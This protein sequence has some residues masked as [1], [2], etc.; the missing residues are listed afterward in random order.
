ST[1]W[2]LDNTIPSIQFVTPLQTGSFYNSNFSL[3]IF[4][5]NHKL[6]YSYY[7]ITNST[8]DV[9]QSNSINLAQA[10]YTWSD[11]VDVDSLA[12][13]NYTVKVFAEDSSETVHNTNVKS[14]WFYVDKTAP[15]A[16][17][18]DG[19][20]VEPTP[21]DNSYTN[22]QTQTFN[23]TC[24]ETFVDE[25]WIDFNGTLDS[26]PTGSSGIYYWWTFASLEGAYSY[27]GY[28]NDTA[29]NLNQTETRTLNVDI[30]DP[31]WSNNKTSP[32]TPDTYSLGASYQFN[33]TWSD[34]FAGLGTAVIEHNFSGSIGN[35]SFSGSSGGEYYYDVNNLAAGVYVWRSYANDS[36]G[37]DAVSDQ[38]SYVVQKASTVL[39]LSPSPG[40][41]VANGTETNISC[42]ANNGEVNF[43]LWRNST[44]IG[45]SIGGTVSDVQTLGI[46]SYNYTCNTSGSQNYTSY[47]VSDLLVVNEKFVSVC[48]LDIIPVNG[49]VYPVSVNATCDCSSPE[50][51]AKLY[52]DSVDVTATENNTA[53]PLAAG[54]Y[55]YVCNVSETQN[56]TYAENSTV[57]TIVGAAS[58]INLTLDGVDDDLTV[59]SGSVVVFNVTL[60]PIDGVGYL[61]ED[62]GLLKSSTTPFGFSKQYVVPGDYVILANHSGS[63]NYTSAN[64]NHTLTVEDTTDPVVS[65]IT[66]LDSDI[67]GW[68]VLLRANATD[69]NLDTIWFEIRNGTLA[70]AVI[71]SGVMNNYQ[72]DLFNGTLY[73][74]ETWPYDVSLLNST[75]L[76]FVVYAN[77]TSGN[78]VN[79]STYW[80]LDNTIPSIQYV[81]P[82]QS[83]GF[84]NSDFNLEIFLANHKLNYSYYNITNSTSDVVQSNSID[85]AQATYTWNDLVDVDSLAEGNYT[86]TT[87]ARDSSSPQNNNTKVTW[88]YVDKTAP[89]LTQVNETGWVVPTPA[90]N[91]YT[92][93]QTQTFN[94]T[95]NETFI[96]EVWIDF[97][98]TL[99]STPTGSSGI[100]YWW[101]FA[102]LEGTYSYTG[103]CNDTAGNQQQTDTRS[104]NVDITPPATVTSLIMLSRGENWIEWSWNNPLDSDYN[105]AILYI[106]DV[107]T[108]NL[109]SPTNSYNLSGL[110]CSEIR[111]LTIHTKDNLDNVNS[112]DVTNVTSTL[113]CPNAVILNTSISPYAVINGSD[114]ELFI[115]AKAHEAV[116]ARIDRPDGSEENITLVNDSAVLYSSIDLMGRY[117]VTFYANNSI[118][119]IVSTTDYFESFEGV[120]FDL[121]VIDSDLVGLDSSFTAYYRNGD[122]AINSSSTGNYTVFMVDTILD[123][124]FHAYSDRLYVTTRDTNISDII[125][126]TLGID[127]HYNTTG[128]LVTY[129]IE[130]EWVISDGAVRIYYD[131]LNY[132]VEG[133]LRLYRCD[134]YVFVNE[135]CLDAWS[136]ITSQSGKN[137]VS[138]YFE[139][140]VTSFSGFSIKEEG[141][142]TPPSTGGAGGGLADIICTPVWVCSN[143]EP[144]VCSESGVQ[145]RSCV[146]RANCGVD[147]GA[148]PPLTRDCIYKE[149]IIETI[150]YDLDMDL[151]SSDEINQGGDF[152][153]EVSLTKEDSDKLSVHLTYTIINEDG[154]VVISRRETKTLGRELEFTKS[155]GT[156]KLEPGDYT[157]IVKATYDGELISDDIKFTVLGEEIISEERAPYT[158]F[159]FK[160]YLRSVHSSSCL[161]FLPSS[162]C[163][164]LVTLTFCLVIILFIAN[165][166]YADMSSYFSYDM[167][168]YISK[169]R[170]PSE[171]YIGPYLKKRLGAF[172]TL[173][174]K[175]ASKLWN[176]FIK[177]VS[178][179]FLAIKK[180]LFGKPPL[181]G[182][183]EGVRSIFNR[184]VRWFKKEVKKD[185]KQGRRMYFGF[186]REVHRDLRLAEQ[187]VERDVWVL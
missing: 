72:G 42:G 65:V 143:W 73:T 125:N 28:C 66:P 53:I 82:S 47:V 23:M 166:Y 133:N 124:E 155:F 94:M 91:A 167:D 64:E 76:T 128:Y 40:W 129:G 153:V 130:P 9:I 107:N 4:L 20:W 48:A 80:T 24:N 67:L 43:S 31:I 171:T 89:N 131:D 46:S 56:Y 150:E 39:T 109:S 178:D 55:D 136:D 21:A 186:R 44:L 16:T 103:Y 137:T 187:L 49:S 182:L 27:T 30:D 51:A 170:R 148:M 173:I 110:I 50:A 13:G 177:I 163:S 77:D 3:E 14:S 185:V 2:T 168:Y 1:Y 165:F 157:L 154:D 158:G 78:V 90:D 45:S 139:I 145:T 174:G 169:R 63:E 118:G 96:D 135:T 162:L 19:G 88:F 134:N 35:D 62:G 183:L 85:L 120:S 22:V 59:E 10:T 104:L 15:N 132:S 87:F 75:D 149:E 180:I 105:S 25:V 98:G 93:V 126:K 26:T 146:D 114:V 18:L 151:D 156:S 97:N 101:T 117:N 6:N 159:S 70:G 61:F 184:D 179:I 7:N 122:V 5:A 36:A 12:E 79:S 138:D 113:T 172:F 106:D 141:V 92:N 33:I 57:Y 52:R 181:F 32:V 140:N 60:A 127:K 37:N 102:S 116:W 161:R 99:D 86:V 100:Y 152:L 115:S 69:L 111:N 176:G 54:D 175:Y 160:S 142:V 164:W 112:A 17:V 34:V 119:T 29:G 95:C 41:S 144:S 38:W 58:I 11:S 81:V 123:L 83:G 68:T 84:Y 108:I 71:D 8:S 74:N 147:A 121:G